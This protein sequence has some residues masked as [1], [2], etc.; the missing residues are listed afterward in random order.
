MVACAFMFFGTDH[1]FNMG[2]PIVFT[3]GQNRHRTGVITR[4]HQVCVTVTVDVTNAWTTE[5]MNCLQHYTPAPAPP[6][7]EVPAS[8]VP[9]MEDEMPTPRLVRFLPCN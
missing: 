1:N 2:D 7:A 9:E 5:P 6:N 3:S 8:P 4:L